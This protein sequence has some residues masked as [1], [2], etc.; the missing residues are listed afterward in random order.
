[1]SCVTD[2]NPRGSIRM[3]YKKMLFKSWCIWAILLVCV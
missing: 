2:K 3:R 1:M